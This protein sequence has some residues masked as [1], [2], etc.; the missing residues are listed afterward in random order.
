MVPCGRENS[1]KRAKGSTTDPVGI[2]PASHGACRT[3]AGKPER[4]LVFEALSGRHVHQ[5]YGSDA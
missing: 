1:P 2:G 3:Y 5:L 4:W